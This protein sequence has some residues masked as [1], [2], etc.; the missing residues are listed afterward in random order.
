M[1]RIIVINPVSHSIS[2]RDAELG[3]T[4]YREVIGSDGVDF[5]SLNKGLSIIVAEFGLV[6]D[7]ADDAYFS[8]GSQL[9]NGTAIVFAHDEHGDDVDISPGNTMLL[10]MNMR[11]YASPAGVEMAIREN[12]IR[13]PVATFNGEV[14]WQ[15]PQRR[16][17]FPLRSKKT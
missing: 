17:D 16:D 9:F 13:R 3:P 1:T 6:G 12:S 14:F 7:G 15:W 11:W 4:L 5:G 10:T 2:E 8:I